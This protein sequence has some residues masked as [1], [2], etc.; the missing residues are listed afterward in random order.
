[1]IAQLQGLTGSPKHTNF[2]LVPAFFAV[3][4]FTGYNSSKL[5]IIK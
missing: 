2:C 3:I 1:M 4:S 5:Q